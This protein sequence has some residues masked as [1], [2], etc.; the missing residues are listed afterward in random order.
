MKKR[1][2]IITFI[3]VIFCFVLYFTYP[4]RVILAETIITTKHPQFAILT[5]I[6]TDKLNEIKKNILNP[7][8]AFSNIENN[9]KLT[10]ENHSKTLDYLTKETLVEKSNE[11]AKIKI[12]LEP[13]QNQNDKK[14]NLK[15]VEDSIIETGNG[16]ELISIE[17]KFSSTHYFKGRLIKITDPSKVHL[18][19]AQIHNK[20]TS[21]ERGEWIDE[22]VSRTGTKAAINAS[23]FND[24]DQMNWGSHPMGIIISNG[25]LLQD[26]DN[27]SGDT[28]LAI[29][30][31][32]KVITGKYSSAELLKLGVRE[33]MSFRPQLIV[34]GKSML[35]DAKTDVWGYQPR[36]AV[37]QTSDGSIVFIQ[38]DGRRAASIGASMKDV[39]DLMLQYDVI[40]A[41]AMD[42]GTSSFLSFNGKT[43]T[44]S[45]ISDPRGRFIPNAWIVTN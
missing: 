3:L 23:G 11:I 7:P 36:S 18:E 16:T 4:L 26:Y 39:A 12:P 17:R 41:M 21:K 22:I 13:L 15:P 27:T 1:L 2:W 8:Y 38:I 20:G 40:N 33:A 14:T 31:Q 45:P 30:L 43:Q 5:L 25:V 24:P 29:T 28:V 6:G 37:G 19:M 10:N 32:N 34:N 9:G 35:E 44:V 42:G